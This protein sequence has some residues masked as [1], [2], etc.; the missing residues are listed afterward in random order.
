MADLVV[1]SGRGEIPFLFKTL[2]REKGYDPVTVGVR[3]ISDRGCDYYVPF[4]GFKQFENLLDE[5]GRP[6]VVMLGKFEPSLLFAVQ[7]SLLFKLRLLLGDDLFKENYETF[8]KLREQTPSLKTA[9]VVLTYL[10]YMEEKG[11]SFLPSE[12]V[13]EIFSPALAPEGNLTPVPFELRSH[14]W[15]FFRLAKTLADAEVGQTLVVKD[16]MV[17]AVEAIEGT[18]ETIKRA[19]RFAGKGPVVIKVGRT[20]Q[21]YRIDIPTVG[22]QTLKLLKRCRAKALFLEAGKVLILEKERFLKK[23]TEAGVAVIGLTPR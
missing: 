20:L 4:L 18:N 7:E 1:L 3:G 12:E 10:R 9:D 15:E 8:K 5:L 2:A 21:D 17:V 16:E 22:M 14:H 23:A 19:C 13:R 11:Y 6:P